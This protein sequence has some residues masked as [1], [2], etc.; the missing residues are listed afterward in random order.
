MTQLV[1]TILE[2][3]SNVKKPQR[4]YISAL[5]VVLTLFQ[6]KANFRNLSRYC[7]LSEK[8]LSR[9]SRRT[10]N[11]ARFNSGLLVHET[12]GSNDFIAAIDASFISKSRNKTEGLGWFY[13]GAAGEAQRGL[14]ISLISSGS[15]PVS[16]SHW[17][18]G[19][20]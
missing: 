7:H 15:R 2:S 16:E 19:F 12:P 14:E 13:N 9:W 5:L 17:L 20:S 3:M 10:F 4:K 1:E 8:C 6:G 18:Q 11:F